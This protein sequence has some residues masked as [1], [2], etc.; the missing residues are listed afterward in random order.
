MVIVTLDPATRY[1]VPSDNLVRDPVSL[2]E[3]T[4]LQKLEGAPRSYVDVLPG[5]GEPVTSKEPDSIVVATRLAES[6][7][8]LS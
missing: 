7:L 2:V 1:D 5:T 8:M 3:Y 4:F 6:I